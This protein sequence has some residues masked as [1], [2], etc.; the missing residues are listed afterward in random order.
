MQNGVRIVRGALRI[1]DPEGCKPTLRL[2]ISSP[3]H[4]TRLVLPGWEEASAI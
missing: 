2:K 3:N 4:V 1:L